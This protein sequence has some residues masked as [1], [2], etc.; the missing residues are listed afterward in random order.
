MTFLE[1]TNFFFHSHTMTR[2][3]KAHVIYA[4]LL[5]CKKPAALL[6]VS[7][8]NKREIDDQQDSTR[9]TLKIL[10]IFVLDVHVYVTMCVNKET[11]VS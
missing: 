4:R 8:S 7:K 1:G 3:C 2:I 9:K 5:V 11:N 6:L 10:I